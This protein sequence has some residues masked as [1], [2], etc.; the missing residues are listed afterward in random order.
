MAFFSHI[1]TTAITFD[2][3]AHAP[4]KNVTPATWLPEY[5]IM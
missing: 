1:T 5:Y 3:E 4:K 2:V